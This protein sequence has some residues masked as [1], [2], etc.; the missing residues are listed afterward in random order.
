[1]YTARTFSTVKDKQFYT[2][3]VVGNDLTGTKRCVDMCL[4]IVASTSRKDTDVKTLWGKGTVD[5]P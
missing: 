1:M 5:S 4:P 3:S 2:M